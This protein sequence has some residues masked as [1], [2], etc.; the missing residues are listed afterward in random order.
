MRRHLARTRVGSTNVVSP[1]SSWPSTRNAMPDISTVDP[2]HKRSYVRRLRPDQPLIEQPEPRLGNT[3]TAL[4]CTLESGPVPAVFQRATDM[5]YGPVQIDSG[6]T[7]PPRPASSS[8]E[9]KERNP[10]CCERVA[11]SVSGSG[12]RT[13]T[14]DMVVNSHPLCQLSYA[15]SRSIDC[16]LEM[17][18]NVPELIRSGRQMKIGAPRRSVK[19]APIRRCSVPSGSR[20]CRDDGAFPGPS[21]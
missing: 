7:G 21:P 14:Y 10:L 8:T 1:V 4:S 2:Q 6:R 15:G 3:V 11:L 9:R 13:R 16:C 19:I 18:A 5:L 20:F 12:G 17:P